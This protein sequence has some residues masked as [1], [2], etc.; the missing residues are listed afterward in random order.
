MTELIQ[1]PT[2]KEFVITRDAVSQA[3]VALDADDTK[4]YAIRIGV[5]GGGCSGFLYNMEFIQQ[6]DI[7]PE[8]DQVHDSYEDV[9]F[10]IDVFSMEY[11]KETTLD[12]QTSLRESG[13]K[14]VSNKPGR[15]TCGCGSSF[16]G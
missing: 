14:F 10:V 11:L 12:Y 8:E 9:L 2:G 1:L 4:P 5:K 6:E 16:S 7:D 13:F 3:R 15:R